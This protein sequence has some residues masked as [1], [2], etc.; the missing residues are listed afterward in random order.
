VPVALAAH[1][2]QNDLTSY[3]SSVGQ[4]AESP[5]NALLGQKN[6]QVQDLP[7]HQKV[8]ALQSHPAEADEVVMHDLVLQPVPED[9]ESED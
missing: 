5:F 8:A 4:E 7:Y 3:L 6:Q 2:Q 9:P 1:R